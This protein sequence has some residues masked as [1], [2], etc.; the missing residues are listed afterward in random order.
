LAE[1]DLSFYSGG[2]EG[3]DRHFWRINFVSLGNGRIPQIVIFSIRESVTAFYVWIASNVERFH[4]AFPHKASLKYL[5]D[6][7]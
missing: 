4:D 1:S 5:Y 7:R 6:W 3:F 2:D